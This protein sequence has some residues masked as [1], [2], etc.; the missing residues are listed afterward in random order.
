MERYQ[1]KLFRYLYQKKLFAGMTGLLTGSVLRA[2]G[3]SLVNLFIPVYVYQLSGSFVGVMIFYSLYHLLV[4]VSAYLAGRIIRLIGVDWA[5]FFGALL[6]AGFLGLMILG[7]NQLWFIWLAAI[8]WGLAV[9]LHWC[10][11]HYS[12]FGLKTGGG[13]FGK[14]TSLI[15][16]AERL[17]ITLAPLIGGL[18]IAG[19]GFTPVFAI[20]FILI[21]LSGL[22]QFFD[23]FTKS[24]MQFDFKAIIK[25][26]IQPKNRRFL[27]GFIGAGFRSVL[28]VS[29]WPLF[30]FLV[31][32]NYTVFGGLKTG[33]Q[34]VSL[35]LIW[36]LGKRIDKKGPEILKLGVILNSIN[37]LIRAFLQS[38]ITIFAS[39]A[40]HG[41]GELLVLE[42]F[43]AA[44]YQSLSSRHKLEFLTFREISIHLGGLVT[45]LIVLGLW[46]LG[47][48]WFWMFSLATIGLIM[49]SFIGNEDGS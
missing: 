45:C 38:P 47:V 36:W 27:T 26:F 12:V 39:E 33:A 24:G 19:F 34:I 13:R 18:L 22:P 9:N 17:G 41:W 30:I 35:F 29:V 49:T 2:I 25:N 48:G 14:E 28:V 20:A 16:L 5:I 3:M 7:K 21:I 42:P 43:D 31:I 1:E 11:Y 23:S 32:K 15:Y 8:L 40:F 6:R 10:S 37:W 46:Y 4:I 44:T